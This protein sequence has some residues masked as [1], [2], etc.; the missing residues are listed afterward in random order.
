MAWGIY[1]TMQQSAG[2]ASPVA[3]A[4]PSPPAP[5]PPPAASPVATVSPEALRIVRLAISAA[6]ADGSVSDVERAAILAPRQV[7]GPADLALPGS[8]TEEP[9]AR[10][11]GDL[12]LERISREHILA[13]LERCGGNKLRAA[14]ILRIPRSSLYQRLSKYGVR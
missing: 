6:Y 10:V 8:P 2:H 7:I 1:E 13:V 3:A 12:S 5:Q 4:A 9:A 11:D 14:R